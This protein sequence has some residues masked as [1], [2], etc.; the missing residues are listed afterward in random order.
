MPPMRF[1]LPLLLLASPALA[2]D[3]PPHSGVARVRTGPELSDLA[4][5][6]MAVAG[7]ALARRAI[8]RRAGRRE[9]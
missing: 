1:V 5:F 8:R 4:L 7:V 6:G 3:P 9:D 2:D